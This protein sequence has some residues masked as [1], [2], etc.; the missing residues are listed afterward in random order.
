MH[1]PLQAIYGLLNDPRIN[2]DDKYIFKKFDT[3][4]FVPEED[5]E[6]I[7]DFH[8]G[9]SFRSAYEAYVKLPNDYLCCIAIY[10]DKTHITSNG[11]IKVEP[12]QISL[13]IFDKETR[14]HQYAW[15]TI[16]YV[17]NQDHYSTTATPKK[18]YGTIMPLSMLFYPHCLT[19]K[20]QDCGLI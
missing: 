7:S 8:E 13:L 4:F 15:H 1:S 11:N 18:S 9:F 20:N 5:P 2:R 19:Y 17:I 12:V 10:L 3:P 6:I 14:L 16:G